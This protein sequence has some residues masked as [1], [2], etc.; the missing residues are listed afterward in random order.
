MNHSIDDAAADY[1]AIT[2]LQAAY[3]DAVTRQAWDELTP[4]FLP[5]CP[6]RLDLHTGAVIEKIGPQEIGTLIADSI[7]RFEFFAFTLQNTV[8]DVGETGTTA[9]GRLYIQELRQERDGHRWTTAFGL[10]RDSYRKDDGVWRFASR[11]YTSLARHAA[12]GAGMDVF[13]IP[14]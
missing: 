13:A 5:D 12:A 1:I 6:V 10:Y 14:R 9:T 8:V 3:G 4:M 7:E 11:D 2:R